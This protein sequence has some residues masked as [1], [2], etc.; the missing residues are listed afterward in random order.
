MCKYGGNS[1][2]PYAKNQLS[3]TLKIQ[4]GILYTSSALKLMP[5]TLFQNQT[6]HALGQSAPGLV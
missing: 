6:G 4:T 3:Y 1:E 2:K 5:H